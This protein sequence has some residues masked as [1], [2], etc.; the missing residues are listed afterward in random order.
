MSQ[1]GSLGGGS[2][3]TTPVTVPN[4][5][6]GDTSFTPYSL[7]AGGTTSTSALQQVSGLGTAGQVL[8]SAGAGAL[9][10]WQNAAVGF[11]WSAPTVNATMV[12]NNG[13]IANKA[14]LLTLTLPATASLGDMI[15][16][17]GINTAVG[18]RIAQNALQ[19]IWYGTSFTGIGAG[20]YLES[21][22]IRD[23]VELV[24]VVAGT[25][26]VWNVLSS[27]GNITVV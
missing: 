26:T 14:G 4:G 13:Y 10:T 12:V 2:S 25:S 15:R 6:T 18:W 8:T 5:G 24:C 19:Q 16:V 20:G 11:T 1:A 21:T 17:T 22:A 9:P 23:S 27:V 7:I 3:I